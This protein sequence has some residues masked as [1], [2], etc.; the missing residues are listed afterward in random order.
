MDDLNI[1]P[2]SYPTFERLLAQ[3]TVG[4][5]GEGG[6]GGG[7][8]MEEFRRVMRSLSA[9]LMFWMLPLVSTRLIL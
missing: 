5:E 7:M 9:K 4:L 8:D 6:V 2:A 3:M 1:S